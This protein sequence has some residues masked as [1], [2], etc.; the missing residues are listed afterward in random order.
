MSIMPPSGKLY[1]MEEEEK[2]MKHHSRKYFS[3]TNA[4]INEKSIRKPKNQLFT[5]RGPGRLKNQSKTEF[6]FED[7]SG[8]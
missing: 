2:F 6:L 5:E 3:H 1:G 8:P 7:V 4:E